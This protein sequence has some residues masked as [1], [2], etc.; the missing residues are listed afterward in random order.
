[1]IR[2]FVIFYEEFDQR[3]FEIKIKIDF[4]QYNIIRWEISRIREKIPPNNGVNTKTIR[5]ISAYFKVQLYVLSH[6][7]SISRKY[8]LCLYEHKLSIIYE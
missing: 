3:N 2:G 5:R 6:T 4:I 8:M 1:M 7:D